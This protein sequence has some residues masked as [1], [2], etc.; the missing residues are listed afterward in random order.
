MMEKP[1][2]SQNH[3]IPKGGFVQRRR[4]REIAHYIACSDLACTFTT[5]LL[6]EVVELFYMDKNLFVILE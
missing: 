4:K 6:T 3:H 5:V 2:I 1:D